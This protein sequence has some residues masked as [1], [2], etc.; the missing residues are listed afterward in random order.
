MNDPQHAVDAGP[1]PR[2]GEDTQANE[3]P[4]AGNGSPRTC[5]SCGWS[6]PSRVRRARGKL[7]RTV[8]R[9]TNLADPF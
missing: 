7:H 5:V 4:G 1:C 6:T 3:T 9:P 2:C 8:A